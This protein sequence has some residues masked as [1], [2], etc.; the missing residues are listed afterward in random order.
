[1]PDSVDIIFNNLCERICTSDT[2][3]RAGTV[4]TGGICRTPVTPTR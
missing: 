2:D 1:V 3:C 4:C